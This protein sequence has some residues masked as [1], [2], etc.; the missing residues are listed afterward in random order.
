MTFFIAFIYGLVQGVAEFLPISSSAHLALLPSV[1]KFPDPGIIFDLSMHVGSAIA[2]LLYFRNDVW[3]LL[4]ALAQIILQRKTKV[5][6]GAFAI[7]M[8]IATIATVFVVLL[9]K[10]IA[11]TYARNNNWIAY[12]LII[13]AVIMFLADYFWPN[14]QTNFMQSN[15][16]PFRAVMIGVFQAL[17]IFPG[18]SRAGAT[19]TISRVMGLGRQEASH[20]SF[21]LSLPII[22]AG[23]L[24]E[25]QEYLRSSVTVDFDLASSVIGGSFALVF[26]LMTIHFFLK[27]INRI[28]LG[29]F[30]L[31]RII[32]AGL[33]LHYLVV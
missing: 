8:V 30:A 11:E 3:R 10:N 5:P 2:I 14:K 13:F 7:N 4:N 6:H 9:L 27:F 20:F 23:F 32:L 28:G 33:V 22:F 16:S 21:L 25:S 1:F 24:A 15:I 17:A 18:V 29:W 31:Y 19:L 12:N 26:G